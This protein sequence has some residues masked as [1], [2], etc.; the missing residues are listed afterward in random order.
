MH[1]SSPDG[2]TIHSV[3]FLFVCDAF[4]EL[5]FKAQSSCCLYDMMEELS[6]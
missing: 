2:Q 3:D 6:F 1:N 5:P 4:I